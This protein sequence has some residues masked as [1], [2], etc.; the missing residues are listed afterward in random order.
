MKTLLLRNNVHI[1]IDVYFRT[2]S[3][4]DIKWNE[5]TTKMQRIKRD[6]ENMLEFFESFHK[7]LTPRQ[8]KMLLNYM[9]EYDAFFYI[10]DHDE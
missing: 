1:S 2:P 9:K 5:E 3:L 10:G 8:F 4:E 7:Y 6:K